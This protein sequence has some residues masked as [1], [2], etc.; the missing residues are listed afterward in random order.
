MNG[1]PARNVLVVP[2]INRAMEPEMNAL[3]PL[4]GP[5]AVARVPLPSGH[6]TWSDP[7]K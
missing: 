3:C 5:F 2:A 6:L 1:E 4:A 7:L